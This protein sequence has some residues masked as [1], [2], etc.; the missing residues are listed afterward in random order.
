[1]HF[2]QNSAFAIMQS[3]LWNSQLLGKVTLGS[4]KIKKLGDEVSLLIVQL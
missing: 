3:A 1:M 4:I 2:A